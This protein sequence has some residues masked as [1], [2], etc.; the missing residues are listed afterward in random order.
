MGTGWIPVQEPFTVWP[1]ACEVVRRHTGLGLKS[2]TSKT[3][4]KA[5]NICCESG[6]KGV[7]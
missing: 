6:G 5:V 1:R 3:D 2:A 4:T 7:F